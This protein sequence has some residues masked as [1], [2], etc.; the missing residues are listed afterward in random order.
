MSHF[1]LSLPFEHNFERHKA[2]PPQH[3]LFCTITKTVWYPNKN[4][5]IYVLK[6]YKSEKKATCSTS[7]ML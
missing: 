2:M 5:L 7:S 6:M 1:N 4:L 3:I